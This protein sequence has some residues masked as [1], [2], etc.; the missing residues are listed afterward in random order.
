MKGKFA[1]VAGGAV[2]GLPLL[3]R[4]RKAPSRTSR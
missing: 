1:L 4:R 3:C 2:L